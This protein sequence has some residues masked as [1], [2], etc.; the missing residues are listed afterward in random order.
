M[1]IETIKRINR[2]ALR[3]AQES[4]GSEN[5]DNKQMIVYAVAIG[6]AVLTYYLLHQYKPSIVMSTK[7]NVKQLDQTRVIIASVVAGL[8]VLLVSHYMKK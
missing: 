6:V 3:A 5:I 7:D 8:L 4:E 1:D 2:D